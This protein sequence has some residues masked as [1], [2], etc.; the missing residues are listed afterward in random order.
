M[1]G[2]ASAIYTSNMNDRD[3]PANRETRLTATWP[4]AFAAVG[5]LW[6]ICWFLSKA[7]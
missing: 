7:L 5:M 3:R 2:G 6:A 4:E 1:K